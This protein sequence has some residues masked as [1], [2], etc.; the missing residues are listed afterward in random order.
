MREK[1]KLRMDL[2]KN[3]KL[4]SLMASEVDDHH[5]A[6]E[7]RNECNIRFVAFYVWGLLSFTVFRK[8]LTK[9]PVRSTRLLG[10]TY[11]FTAIHCLF[12]AISGGPAVGRWLN[13]LDVVKYS[14]C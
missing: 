4:K 3:E 6:I 5:A 9:A 11:A 10:R 1:E 14:S 13:V 12:A 8:G 2:E 7:R